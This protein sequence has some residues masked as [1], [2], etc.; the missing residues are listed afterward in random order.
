[1]CSIV[2]VEVQP[3]PLGPG[4]FKSA[5]EQLPAE[6]TCRFALPYKSLELAV[7]RA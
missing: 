7:R 4:Q 6:H 3:K 1:M 5:W 2:L